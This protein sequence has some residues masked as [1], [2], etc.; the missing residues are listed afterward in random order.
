[1][2]QD[3]RIV[4]DTV[5]DHAMS[6]ADGASVWGAAFYG[7]GGIDSDGNAS[8]LHHNSTG[9]LAGVDM[10]LGD[11]FRAGIG[12]GSV[13]NN[14]SEPGRAST[15][16]GS[17]GHVV[18]YAGWQ[19]D[20]LTLKLGGDYGWG[21]M[22]ITRH[23]SA[24]SETNKASQHQRIAQVFGEA[25]Y[26]FQTDAAQ[27]QP[28]ADIAH[29]SAHT[30]AFTE[31]GGTSALSGAARDD[32]AS[33]ATLGVRISLA[34][35][36]LDDTSIVPKLGIGWQHA[37]N[38]FAPDQVLTLQNAAQDFTVQGAPLGQDSAVVQAGLGLLLSPALVLD[39]EYDGAFSSRS[40]DHGVRGTLRWSF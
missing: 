29:I 9:F 17:N 22:D 16:S 13:S 23:V 32:D 35:V 11:G 5:L 40:R 7:N 1:M 25:A 37:F 3:G 2:I 10:P 19:D 20:A 21:D 14:A 26:L 39:V 6:A 33:F 38:R 8:A 4:R 34:D 27:I 18:A 24:L 30:G 12:A 36:K 28:Y 31:K 15:A